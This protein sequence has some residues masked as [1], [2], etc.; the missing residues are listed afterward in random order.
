MTV[1]KQQVEHEIV[2]DNLWKVFGRNPSS[3]LESEI[4][5]KSRAEIQEE[6]ETVLNSDDLF[7]N[8]L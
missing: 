4:L 3:A 1:E 7:W 5:S 2:V 8:P 6:F